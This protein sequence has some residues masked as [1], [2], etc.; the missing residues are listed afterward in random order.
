M[1]PTRTT[2]E[3]T[4]A[5][6][7]RMLTDHHR[8]TSRRFDEQ[9]ERL[10][11]LEHHLVNPA[12]PEETLPIRMRDVEFKVRSIDK[13]HE[14]LNRTA[15]GLIVAFLGALITSAGAWIWKQI[16]TGAKASTTERADRN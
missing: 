15:M 5:D 3:P 1:S 11:V 4:N 6:L 2:E 7:A 14:R 10:A 13:K 12:Q 9:G 16:E 8:E